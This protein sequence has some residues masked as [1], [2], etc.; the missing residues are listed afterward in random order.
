MPSPSRPRRAPCDVGVLVQRD[1]RPP[2]V[3]PTVPCSFRLEAPSTSGRRW[4]LALARGAAGALAART[5]ADPAPDS[6]TRAGCWPP[7]HSSFSRQPASRPSPGPCARPGKRIE[8]AATRVSPCSACP[9]AGIGTAWMQIGWPLRRSPS[10]VLLVRGGVRPAGS[11]RRE[12]HALH[13]DDGL[14]EQFR[15]ASTCA[16]GEVGARRRSWRRR[17]VRWARSSRLSS[18]RTSAFAVS[19]PG[20]AVATRHEAALLGRHRT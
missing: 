16:A 4:R 20:G 12:P 14:R 7:R 5:S 3:V 8:A 17:T 6:A 9:T 2:S 1:R 15:I 19:T 10:P 11:R 13:V 18:L